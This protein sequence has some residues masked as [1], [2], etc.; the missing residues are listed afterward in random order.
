MQSWT[1]TAKNEVLAKKIGEPNE[2]EK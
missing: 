2:T 1:G